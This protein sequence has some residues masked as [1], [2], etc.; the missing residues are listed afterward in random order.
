MVNVIQTMLNEYKMHD[1]NDEVNALREIIQKIIL[2]GLSRCGFFDVAIL[3]G[4]TASRI[5]HNIDR[6]SRDLNF[7]LLA[8][9]EYFRANKYLDFMGRELS[10]YGLDVQFIT[11]DDNQRYVLKFIPKTYL[12]INLKVFNEIRM[13]FEIDN[14]S[15]NFGVFEFRF[16]EIPSPHKIRVFDEGSLFNDIICDI[17]NQKSNYKVSGRILYDFAYYMNKNIKINLFLIK[18]KLI[19][20]EIILDEVSLNL[21]D[22]KNMLIKKFERINYNNAK[23]DVLSLLM[24]ESKLDFWN[25]KYFIDMVGNLKEE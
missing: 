11:K 1:F 24:D 10:A 14:V 15:Q 22:L 19:E 25:D 8:P 13:K 17:L 12:G 23:K 2:S 18:G 16:K 3:C 5:Y 21:D 20:M 7:I 6:F 4:E 9:N